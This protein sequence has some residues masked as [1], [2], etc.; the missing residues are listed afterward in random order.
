MS[1]AEQLAARAAKKRSAMPPLPIS[2]GNIIDSSDGNINNTTPLIS[3]KIPTLMLPSSSVPPRRGMPTRSSTVQQTQESIVSTA[4]DESSRQSVPPKPTI[5]EKTK[6]PPENKATA[7]SAPR[8]SFGSAIKAKTSKAP[9]INTSSPVATTAKPVAK[10]REPPQSPS[11]SSIDHGSVG[12]SPPRPT[13]GSKR[14]SFNTSITSLCNSIRERRVEGDPGSPGVSPG[15]GRD[16]NDLVDESSIGDDYNKGAVDGTSGSGS[17]GLSSLT[18]SYAPQRRSKSKSSQSSITQNDDKSPKAI[19]LLQQ[20]Q[21]ILLLEQQHQQQQQQKP[22]MQLEAQLQILK[23]QMNSQQANLAAQQGAA[24]MGGMGNNQAAGFN[25]MVAAAQAQASNGNLPMGS[26]DMTALLSAIHN[27]ASG[28]NNAGG[29]ANPAAAMAYQQ[30]LAQVAMFNQMNSMRNDSENTMAG[31]LNNVNNRNN[32][33]NNGGASI[34]GNTGNNNQNFL[35]TQQQQSQQ[36]QSQH[37]Q[38]HTF[39]ISVPLKSSSNSNIDPS[40]PKESSNSNRRAMGGGLNSSFTRAQ[41]IGLKNSFTQRRPN[42]HLNNADMH[43]TLKSSLMSIESLTLDDID[44]SDFGGGNMEGVFEDD[45]SRGSKGGRVHGR[46]P[47]DM[48]DVSALEYEEK[49]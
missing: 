20:Q 44:G 18:K 7:S 33:G 26:N 11:T 48:S 30:Q 39:N 31:N 23:M 38:E 13:T 40:A 17:G 46:G 1:F 3:Y 42:R 15:N 27:S 16:Y 12:G 25:A 37:Q 2:S 41:R 5:A 32:I 34:F 43:N 49:N 47:H 36:H 14:D 10:Y 4:R 35:Q 19:L 28:M 45:E 6:Q 24:A 9:P 29:M 8:M 21:Q 22:Q